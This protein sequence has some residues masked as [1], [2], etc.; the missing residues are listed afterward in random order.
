LLIFDRCRYSPAATGG[1]L[2][3]LHCLALGCVRRA[4]VSTW[5]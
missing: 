4:R 3:T 2:R 1:P 5:S